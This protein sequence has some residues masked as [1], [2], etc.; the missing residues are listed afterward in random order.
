[1]SKVRAIDWVKVGIIYIATLLRVYRLDSLTEFL[2]DQGRTMLVMRRFIEDGV[3]PLSGPTTL[4]GHNL[5]PIF[6]YLLAP[7]YLISHGP[8][9]VSMWSALLGVLSV[10]ILY[11]A[12]TLMFGIWPAR[13]VSLLWAVSPVIIS[14]DR[15]IWEPNLVPLWSVLFIFLLYRA[16]RKWHGILWVGVGASVGVLIQLHYP[17][18]YFLGLTALALAGAKIYRKKSNNDIFRS[19]I[20]CTGGFVAVLL[21]FLWY[22]FTVGFK[23]ITGIASIIADGA[24]ATMGKR[25][26]LWQSLDYSYRV[27][28]RMIPEM[29]RIPAAVLLLL[30][31]IFVLFRPTPK[32]IFFS[33]W[34]AGGIAAMVRYAGVVHDH[35]L[36]FLT[37]VPFFM[38]ASVVSSV[39]NP[40]W[41][42]AVLLCLTGLILYQFMQTDIADY[43][44]NDLARVSM[45]V[46]RMK[47][48]AGQE[49]FSFTLINTRSFSDLH[50]R[51]YMRVMGVTPMPVGEANYRKLYVMCE[52][53]R[54]PT[55]TQIT[56]ITTLPVL[57][58]DEHCADT[59]TGIPLWD[60]WSYI[61]HERV[62]DSGRILGTLYVFERRQ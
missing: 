43:G 12:V 21:P 55:V 27:L 10:A 6:Y 62:V 22:E 40:V 32:N 51:Y 28:G 20:W 49:R 9:G 17:N 2:G 23:D 25:V 53:S 45:A 29:S 34:F 57:C 38:L 39:T 4:S 15:T 41:K 24:G 56:S 36:F 1:M 61:R 30:W 31:G 5:G 52:S 13:V 19:L 42:K 44:K 54:C 26:M 16:Y 60:S 47:A 14:A 18:I 59:Y 46:A 37:P 33:L 35:Y 58:Y 3:V 7:G 48:D 8:F 11:R 50:Y